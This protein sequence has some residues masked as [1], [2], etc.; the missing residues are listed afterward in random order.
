MQAEALLSVVGERGN[1]YSKYSDNC[2]PFSLCFWF[3]RLLIAV[4]FFFYT[5]KH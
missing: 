2:H 5:Y 4:E 1:E 3:Y